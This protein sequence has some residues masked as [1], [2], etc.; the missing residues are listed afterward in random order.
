MKGV[1]KL[2]GMVFCSTD[3]QYK[4]P[5]GPVKKG[6]VINFR[7]KIGS[8]LNPREVTLIFDRY[9][10]Q[11]LF[12]WKMQEVRREENE[13][14]FEAKVEIEE[15]NIYK[16]HFEFWSYN[17]KMVICKKWNSFEGYVKPRNMQLEGEEWQLT[18]YTPIA[19]HEEMSQ[20]IMYQIFPDRFC[21]Y[22]EI[23]NLPTDRIY[24]PWGERPFFEDD[25]ICSDYFGGNLQGIRH[26]LKFLKELGV[27]VLYLNPIWLASSNHR[28]NT[29]D[30]RE[31]DPILGTEEDL[32][33]LISEAHKNG[34]IIILDTVLNHTG[35]DS[36]YFNKEGRF[37][38][39]GAYN[40]ME[41]EYFDWYYFHEYPNK[42]ESWW[43]FKTLPK[44]NQE[45]KNFQDYM[46]GENGTLRYW[47]KLGIDGLRLD[48]A[49]E[50]PNE[51]LKKIFEVARKN[52][53]KVIIIGEVWEDASN[54]TNYGHRMEYFLG[55]ELTS[56]MNY[57]VKEAILAYIRYGGEYWSDNLSETLTRIFIENYPREIA[58]SVMNFLSSHDTVRA[59]TKLAG[60][61]VDNHDKAW[62]NSHDDLS[63][64]EYKL[65]RDRLIISYLMVYFLPGIPS[66]FYGDEVGLAGQKD[67]FCRKCY[68]WGRRDKKL[69]KFFKRL[70]KMRKQNKAFFGTADFKVIRVNDEICVL[71]RRNENKRLVLVINRTDRV[72]NIPEDICKL[73][74]VK[75]VFVAKKTLRNKISPYG[76]VILEMS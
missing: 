66:I 16:Y 12:E 53:E 62:Q 26:R 6:G 76:G 2:M 15:V 35:S 56:V 71:E 25:T 67:P 61:E 72:L 38:S 27:T 51:T 13:V 34:M 39:L 59:I 43:G 11:G 7:V 24:R 8:C 46:F 3:V 10:M 75:V 52:S 48:V 42:Y 31:V 21:K 23:Q 49:D 58:Y 36:V 40:S 68:P 65:G 60:P 22:G 20:G 54:K 55:S 50:L 45:S 33:E 64:E 5:V 19:T 57:P 47:Y 73:N 37:Q 18:V 44:I 74:S 70:G 14:V 28:Y 32:L 17:Q 69:L 30:Y 29:S 1:K 41:S 9:W 4:N 63:R